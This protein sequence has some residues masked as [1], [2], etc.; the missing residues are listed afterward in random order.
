VAVGCLGLAL[1]PTELPH[2]EQPTFVDAIFQNR[3]VIWS[4]RLL[5]VAAALVLAAGGVFIVGSTIVRMKSGDW[6]KRAGP[7]E[8][9]EAAVG[10]MREQVEFWRT[11]ALAA[12]ELI[13]DLAFVV[14]SYANSIKQRQSEG[15][16][17]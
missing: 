8:V 14:S 1:Y 10:E 3:G 12:Q 4:A 6:L 15:G 11:S 17:E 2:P 5:L 7:F 13:S 9:S 16:A